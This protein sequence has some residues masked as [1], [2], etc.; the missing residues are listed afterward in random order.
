[1]N[2]PHLAE[3]SAINKQLQPIN[4]HAPTGLYGLSQRRLFSLLRFTFCLFPFFPLVVKF[5]GLSVPVTRISSLRLCSLQRESFGVGVEA[6]ARP[7]FCLSCLLEG[8]LSVML[9]KAGRNEGEFF[10]G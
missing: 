1:V 10:D 9:D 5:A 6:G 4:I 3:L 7:Y 2:M 8:Y